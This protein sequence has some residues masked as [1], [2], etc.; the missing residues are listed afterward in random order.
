MVLPDPRR[1]AAADMY[2]TSGA[3]RRR[4]IVRIEFIAAA[5]GCTAVGVAMLLTGSIGCMALGAWLIGV[6]ANYAPLAR[7]AQRLSRPGSLEAEMTRGDPSSELRVAARAQ[8]WIGVPLAMR[9]AALA[10]PRRYPDR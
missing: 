4:R 9:L 6:G 10:T 5:C 8:L 2:G 3:P 1:L 7:E